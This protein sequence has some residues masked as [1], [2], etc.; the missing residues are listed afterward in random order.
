[1]KTC[2]KINWYKYRFISSVLKNICGDATEKG[3]NGTQKICDEIKIL[4]VQINCCLP[5]R[6][7]SS[8]EWHHKEF[9]SGF[10][11]TGLKNF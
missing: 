6:P 10:E 7:L 2:T 1:M 3:V 5:I 9:T 11:C 4:L 8:Y